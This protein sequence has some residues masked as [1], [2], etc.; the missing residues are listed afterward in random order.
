MALILRAVIFV[1]ISVCLYPASSD[2]AHSHGVRRLLAD[3][4]AS[5]ETAESALTCCICLEDFAADPAVFCVHSRNTHGAHA[6]CLSHWFKVDRRSCP[7]C[8][9]S[10][11]TTDQDFNS[12]IALRGAGYEELSS[13][14]E[15]RY[16]LFMEVAHSALS[17]EDDDFTVFKAGW[18]GLVLL[19]RCCDYI[20]VCQVALPVIGFTLVGCDYLTQYA[21]PY[22]LILENLALATASALATDSI[23]YLKLRNAGQEVRLYKQSIRRKIMSLITEDDSFTVYRDFMNSQTT[24]SDVC[25]VSQNLKMLAV[26]KGL[27]FALICR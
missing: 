12:I 20:S 18:S 4:A 3:A 15:E 1:M 16:D 5:K 14:D 27:F 26:T 2:S 17:E 23:I 24:L 10:K 6:E 25:A 7:V 11:M 22:S 21:H 9:N 13:T 8:K 19:G